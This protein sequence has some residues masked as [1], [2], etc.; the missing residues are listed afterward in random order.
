MICTVCGRDMGTE[1][2]PCPHCGQAAA[3]GPLVRSAKL[4]DHREE[5]QLKQAQKELDA[6]DRRK[7]RRIAHAITGVITIFILNT[8]FGLPETLKLLPILFNL[9]VSLVFGLPIGFLISHFGGGQWRGGWISAGVFFVASLL[10]SIPNLVRGGSLAG[11]MGAALIVGLLG[12]IP[13]AIIGMH[14]DVDD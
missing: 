9:G 2:P 14:V 13:G 3:T 7:R 5:V 11:A 6:K 8:M 12:F 10:L 1:P 4:D